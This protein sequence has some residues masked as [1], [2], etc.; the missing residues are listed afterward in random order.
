[1]GDALK[2]AGVSVLD[3]RLDL[4]GSA[5]VDEL[6]GWLG[7]LSAS[8]FYSFATEST[9]V[10]ADSPRPRAS[11]FALPGARTPG[12]GTMPVSA[13]RKRM[14]SLRNCAAG[15]AANIAAE[16]LGLGYPYRVL[17]GIVSMC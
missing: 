17:S 8:I 10:D 16:G 7:D 12:M 6:L 11:L 4:S 9:S 14:S 15:A 2:T 5:A 1:V 13:T 3:H